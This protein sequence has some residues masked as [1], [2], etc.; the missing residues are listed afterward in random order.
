[1]RTLISI[2]LALALTPASAGDKAKGN[3]KS[4]RSAKADKEKRILTAAEIQRYMTPY[5]ANVQKCYAKHG[6]ADKKSTGDLKLE[7]IIHKDGS[8]WRI[9]VVAPGVKN[10]KLYSCV[11]DL[12]KKWHFA[13]RK[14]FTHALIPFFYLK[15]KE[16]AG[17]LYS[18]WNPKGCPKKRRAQRK[19]VRGK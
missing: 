18:C 16:K 10:K 9:N 17:P 2:A 14:G 6:I 7:L 3:D 19:K 4:S 5:T 1:M 15:S 8:V 13:P 12:A 11:K